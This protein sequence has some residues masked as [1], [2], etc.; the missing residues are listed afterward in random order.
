VSVLTTD[1]L[2][3]G[4]GP[5]G[6]AAALALRRHG[7]QVTVADAQG[8][9]ID[10]VCG[11][12][13]MPDSVRELALLG[14]ELSAA[15]GAEFSGI[16]FIGGIDIID[17]IDGP[18]ACRSA[19]PRQ[20]TSR[21]P[22][23]KGLGLRRTVLHA[24]MVQ[25]A[26]EAGVDLKW[27]SRVELLPDGAVKLAGD[28]VRYGLLVGADGQ[29][30]QVRRWAGLEANALLIRRFGFRQHF[31][32]KPWSRY[33]EVHWGKSGQAYV[34]PVSPDA[35]CLVTMGRDPKVRLAEALAEMPWLRERLHGVG[36]ELA[37]MDSAR[38]CLMS[39]RRLRHVTRGRVALVGDASGSVDAIT[40]EG[41]AM[42]A[43]QALLLAECVGEAGFEERAIEAGLSGYDRLHPRTLRIPHTMARA[44]LLMDRWPV[45][46]RRAMRM[47][48]GEPELFRRMLGVHVGAETLGRFLVAKGARVAWRM[49]VPGTAAQ[50][51]WV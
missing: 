13:L 31:A 1:V 30:S 40:G 18:E 43:R 29:S 27:R 2:V 39:T 34:A 44:M 35:V 14:V 10:K 28:A 6:L 21:F 25:R 26:S 23:G 9:S 11:E 4:G 49:A 19:T 47:L 16:Q 12:G 51:E 48:T 38:G 20:V 15:D 7:A 45:V 46:G 5:A 36:T 32:V 17:F 3:V 33:V 22:E 24:R 41:I 37:A 42:A 50:A 8:P